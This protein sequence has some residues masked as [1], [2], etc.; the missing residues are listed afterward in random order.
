MVVALHHLQLL[1]NELEPI[2]S[3]H[4]LH[5]MRKGRWLSTLK[6]SKLIPR[7]RWRRLRL[8]SLHVDHTLLHSLK[9]LCLHN[10]YLLK[11]RRRGWWRVGILVVLSVADPIVVVVAVPCIGHLKYKCGYDK[12][13]PRER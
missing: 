13:Y 7:R 8:S 2:I 6:I 1:L 10:Q 12:E 3:I 9:H 4:R 11:S 5:S